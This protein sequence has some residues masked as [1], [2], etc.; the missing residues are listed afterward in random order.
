[1]PETLLEGEGSRRTL[2]RDYDARELTV[3]AGERIEALETESGWARCRADDGR[4]GWL[5]GGC[6][7]PL[8]TS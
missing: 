4:E 1:M 3:R 6:V 2:A 8:A 5:P 7:K